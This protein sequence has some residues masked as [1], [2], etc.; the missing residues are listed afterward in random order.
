MIVFSIVL[1][2]QLSRSISIKFNGTALVLPRA[3][4]LKLNIPAHAG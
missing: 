4:R 2:R 1:S 3:D